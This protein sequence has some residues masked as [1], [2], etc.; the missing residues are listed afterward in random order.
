[1]DLNRAISREDMAAE[2]NDAVI[3]AVGGEAIT[4][5]FFRPDDKITVVAEAIL[6][7]GKITPGRYLVIGGGSVGL[8]TAEYLAERGAAVCVVE[9]LAKIGKGLGPMSLS[10]MRDRLTKAGIPL[11]TKTRVLSIRE[12]MVRVFCGRRRNGTWSF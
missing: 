1:M 2:E 11:L 5:A 6:L 4:P 9:M 10:L 12:G 8:E 3:Y 7:K